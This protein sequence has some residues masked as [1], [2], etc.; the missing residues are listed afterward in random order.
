M[1]TTLSK[2]QLQIAELLSKGKKTTEISELLGI[3]A[4]TVRYYLHLSYKKVGVSN[5]IS[6]A[7]KILAEV[8]DLK[9]HQIPRNKPERNKL[10]T[11]LRWRDGE[12]CC[13]CGAL[14]DFRLTNTK[15]P[16]HASFFYENKGSTEDKLKLAHVVC[17]PLVG[18]EKLDAN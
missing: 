6:L 9:P 1:I 2:R 12:N 17:N 4:Q 10:M 16:M 15:D 8:E 7:R 3:K 18:G 14:I 5:R 11:R 13:I